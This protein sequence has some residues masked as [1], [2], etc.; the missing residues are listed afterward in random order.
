MLSSFVLSGAVSRER[1]LREHGRE[2]LYSTLELREHGREWLYSTLELR[3]H[4]R[5]WLYSTLGSSMPWDLLG[6]G[7]ELNLPREKHVIRIPRF[8]C[9]SG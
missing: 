3:E 9:D 5:E 6:V 7:T 2:W 4:G 1:E 8:L